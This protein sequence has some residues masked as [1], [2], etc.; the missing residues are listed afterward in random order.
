[1][2]IRIKPLICVM[3]CLAVVFASH[4]ILSTHSRYVLDGVGELLRS[5]IT[6]PKL[7]VTFKN[8]DEIVD[9]ITADYNEVISINHDRPNN[10]TPPEADAEWQGWVNALG[11][12]VPDTV[13]VT[14]NV[15]FN[16]K[17]KLKDYYVHYLDLD[18]H[19]VHE[20]KIDKNNRTIDLDANDLAKLNALLTTMENSL[21]TGEAGQYG[22]QFSVSWE[23]YSIPNPVAD[24][25]VSPA[26]AFS[27]NDNADVSINLTPQVD[28][29]GNIIDDNGDGYPDGYV[30]NG[31][32]TDGNQQD[33][34]IPDSVLGSPVKEIAAGS[35]SNFEDLRDVYIPN[36]VE[37]IGAEAFSD[38]SYPQIQIFFDGTKAE[39]DALVAASDGDWDDHIGTGS[40]VVCLR[41]DPTGYYKQTGSNGFLGI[42][43]KVEWT[44]Q[45]GEYGRGF[46]EG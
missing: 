16:A 25:Y 46:G 30:V 29:N 39:W 3:L 14:K 37:Y 4:T 9:I 23:S 21:N 10:I 42:G 44:W 15:V 20:E 40:V 22:L 24:V 33:F 36:T 35:F 31:I 27:S 45:S 5:I 18:G 19:I 28:N 8:G 2:R 11:A 26:V 38:N 43:V 1:M 6:G 32:D 12:T 17:W 13:R 7:T 34:I 41:G